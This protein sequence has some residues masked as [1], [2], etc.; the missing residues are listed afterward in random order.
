MAVEASGRTGR[1]GSCSRGGRRRT[2]SWWP[3]TRG[4]GRHIAHLRPLRRA[5][6]RACRPATAR[7]GWRRGCGAASAAMRSARGLG[8]AGARGGRGAV[9][10]AAISLGV[11]T[12]EHGR[13]RPGRRGR[14]VQRQRQRPLRP[15]PVRL[16]PRLVAGRAQLV[17]QPPRRA[18]LGVGAGAAILEAGRG[19]RRSSRRRSRAAGDHPTPGSLRRRDRRHRPRLRRPGAPGR[20]DRGGRG[21]L[22]RAHR[23]LPRA[24]RPP[25]PALNAF[26]VVLAERAL[27]EADQADGRRAQRRRAARCSASRSRSRTTPTSPAR[28]TALGSTPFGD[29]ATRGRRGRAPAARRRRRDR[30]QDPRPRA[31]IAPFTETPTFGVTRNPWDLNRTPGGSSGGSAAAVAAGLVRRRARLRRRRLDPHPGRLLRP[32]RPQAPARPH[33][34]RAQGRAPGTA[35]RSTARSRAASPTPRCSSTRPATASRS[36]RGGRDRPAACGSRSRPSVPPPILGA[37][38]R[39]AARR[40]RRRPRSC[41]AGSATRSSSATPTTARAAPAFA[42]RYLRGIHDE[43]ARDAAPRAALAPHA[44]LHAPRAPRSRRAVLDAGAR[45]RRRRPPHAR[46]PRVRAGRRPAHADVH[47]PPAPD[48]RPTRAAARCGRS[49]ATRAGCPYNAAVQP[50]RPARRLGARPASPPTASRSPSS[51]SAAPTTRRRCS[52]SPRRSS[53]SAPW[54]DRRRRTPERRAARARRARSRARPAPSCARRSPARRSRSRP[55]A[56]RPT[57][58]PRPTSPPSTLI[59]ERARSPRGPTTACSARRARDPPGTSGLRW[60]VDPLDGTANFLFGIP[61]WGVSIAVEDER[62]RSPASSSTRCATSAGRPRAA[63][64]PTLDGE[65]LR[66]PRARGGPRDRARRDRLRLR[67]R[68]A[69]RAGRGRRPR[70]SRRCATSAASARAAIDLAWTAAGRYDAYYERGVKLWDIAAG[71]LICASAGLA[72]RGGSTPAPPAGGGHP[73]RAASRWRTSSRHCVD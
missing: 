36:R 37:A 34:D 48:R 73:R 29:P 54:A 22:A 15:H 17:V 49:T 38:G 63:R 41:C 6:R 26:R 16:D 19:P 50:H 59:R 33:L 72:H 53:A 51:S 65:P 24:D 45:A 8:G 47:A 7:G 62:G 52:R 71:E 30:R 61:Q 43:A 11:P 23:G 64:T 27:A 14:R 42:A 60:I 9:A 10:A 68:R 28:S 4:P 5:A 57:S 13:R 1:C 66:R 20:A 58:S 12:R 21:L 40:A 55:R 3:T 18:P 32:V 31:E 44:R 67:R 2:C 46:R 69:R 25:G 35:S 56:P 39:R 70:C